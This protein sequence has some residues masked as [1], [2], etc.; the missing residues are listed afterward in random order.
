M[1]EVIASKYPKTFG[2]FAPRRY[3]PPN[4]YLNPV[5]WAA[6][7][8][9]CALFWKKANIEALPHI[10]CA[11]DAYSHMVHDAPT[12]FI[13]KEYAQAVHQTQIPSDDFA[14]SELKWPREALLFVLPSDFS[15]KTF[16]YLV[17]F[18][19]VSLFPAGTYPQN[20]SKWDFPVY[21]QIMNTVD[22]INIHFQTFH[23]DSLPVDYTGSY[24]LNF[25]VKDVPAAPYEDSTLEEAEEFGAEWQIPAL[26]PTTEADD[27]KLQEAVISFAVKLMCTLTAR[28]DL[29]QSGACTR[30]MRIKHGKVSK[31][32]LWSPN[33]IGWAYRAERPVPQGGT[34]A[35]PRLHWRRG[36]MRNQT[37]GPQSGLRKLI[38]IEPVLVNAAAAK[39]N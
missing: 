38:W 17:P 4:G 7:E 39:G 29:I 3:T 25:K 19:S 24:P 1:L 18:I 22:R 14:F 23:A 37:Y 30:P 35:S 5:Y 26:S 34:H 12:Y 21:A 16:G 9:A 28:P 31:A 11:A 36:H 2:T 10:T 8:T 15:I 6:S 32:E 20:T 13:G 27:R 33:V